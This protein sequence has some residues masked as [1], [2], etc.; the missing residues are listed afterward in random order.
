MSDDLSGHKG[1]ALPG[2][3]SGVTEK[4]MKALEGA[5]GSGN[6]AGTHM[7][8]LEEQLDLMTAA[9]AA[10][11]MPSMAEFSAW[12]KSRWLLRKNMKRMGSGASSIRR[13]QTSLDQMA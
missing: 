2:R 12:P 8:V 10:M 4:G 11:P 3:I 6:Y 13:S 1:K 7:K 5:A 9:S